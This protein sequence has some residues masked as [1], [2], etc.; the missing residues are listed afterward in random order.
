MNVNKEYAPIVGAGNHFVSVARPHVDFVFFKRAFDMLFAL[1]LLPVL[2]V[3]A[4]TLVLLN[5]F[6]NRG[7]LLYT[8]Q[9]MGQHLRPFTIY[10]FRSMIPA[11]KMVRTA[12]DPVES[13]RI[14]SLGRFIRLTRIDEL[15]QIINV[16]KG[17]MSLIGPR[18][19]Y[20]EHASAFLN[21]VP[22]YRARFVAKPGISGLAQV[23][24]G[25]VEGESETRRKARMDRYYIDNMG[26]KL[27]AWIFVKTLIVVAGRLGAK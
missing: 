7:P 25:Y 15:P 8:Q 21:S 5:P 22:G 6:F 13:D 18:P 3:L 1:L 27:E 4:V 12:A 26:Y 9:R 24:L 16:L 10:K 19:D 14:T 20:I 17:D 23:R 11:E 2:C